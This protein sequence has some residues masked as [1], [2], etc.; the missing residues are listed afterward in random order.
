MK[1]MANRDV[2][3]EFLKGE[4]DVRSHNGNLYTTKV[5]GMIVLVNYTTPLAVLFT[6][7]LGK[8]DTYKALYVNDNHYSRT[9]SKLQTWLG[10]ECKNSSISSVH[11][12]N[13]NYLRHLV[14]HE[15]FKLLGKPVYY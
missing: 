5:N 14:G 10:Y 1:R 3:R 12:T 2:I 8:Y 7:E 6:P 15:N 9:T 11:H 13:E 4:S